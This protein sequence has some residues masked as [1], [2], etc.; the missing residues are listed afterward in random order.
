M[1]AY[2]NALAQQDAALAAQA[3][4][5]GQQQVQFGA[6]LLGSGANLL[7]SYTQGLTGAYSPFTT[8]LGIGSQIE[9]LG[10]APLDIGAQLGGRSAQAGA[11]VGQS[12]FQGGVLGARTNQAA[13]G[14][15][16]WG[17]L[18]SGLGNNPQAREALQKLFG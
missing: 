4:Q 13:Q 16:A 10:Q 2:Y 3:T 11:N 9:S 18:L 14:D 7:G 1:E 5:A 8:G 6:G 12:L 15:S 17:D